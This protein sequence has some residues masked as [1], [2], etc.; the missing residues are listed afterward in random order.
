[1]LLQELEGIETEELISLA[2]QC[3]EV[4]LENLDTLNISKKTKK[5]IQGQLTPQQKKKTSA[6]YALIKENDKVT[7]VKI[8]YQGKTLGKTSCSFVQMQKSNRK[9]SDFYGYYK[10]NYNKNNYTVLFSIKL[11]V[12][13]HFKEYSFTSDQL[14]LKISAFLQKIAQELQK[15][16]N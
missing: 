7:G 5:N 12:G 16:M 2:K 11:G 6:K 8:K 4:T 9:Y 14:E 3:D 15:K 10:C 13:V 1:M